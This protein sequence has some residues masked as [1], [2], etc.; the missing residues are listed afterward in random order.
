MRGAGLEVD[1]RPPRVAAPG[2][3]AVR[4]ALPQPRAED[5]QHVRLLER[6]RAPSA[7]TSS[8]SCPGSGDGR[9]GTRPG[10]ARTSITGTASASA[11]VTQPA[12]SRAPE[13]RRPGHDHAPLRCGQPLEHLA[14]GRTVGGGPWAA[15]AGASDALPAAPRP[16]GP[17]GA[18]AGSGP[19]RPWP[20]WRTASS[21]ITCAALGGRRAPR[22]TW[23]ATRCRS[24]G[25]TPGTPRDPGARA[26]LPDEGNQRRGVLARGVDADRG[27][28]GAHG[29]GR[30]APPAAGR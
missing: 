26:D 1:V 9:W 30:R 13:A 10:D 5:E 16:A 6:D 21:M 22:P 23:P 17:R 8:R 15:G 2:S 25:P 11:R 19:G 28:G 7:P 18:P 12:C 14:H 29:A 4:G 20:S 27:V 3:V 24:R